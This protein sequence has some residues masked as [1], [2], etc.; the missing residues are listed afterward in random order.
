MRTCCLQ[1]VPGFIELV[2]KENMGNTVTLE[3]A[4]HL[5]KQLSLVDKIPTEMIKQNFFS[6]LYETLSGDLRGYYSRRINIQHC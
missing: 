2:S 3:D 4:H 6:P 5:V 1:S